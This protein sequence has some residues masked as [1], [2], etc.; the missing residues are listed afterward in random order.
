MAR[1]IDKDDLLVFEDSFDDSFG[2]SLEDDELDNLP[3]AAPGMAKMPSSPA[4]IPSSP[5]A[6]Q[7]SPVKQQNRQFEAD[8]VIDLDSDFSDDTPRSSRKHLTSLKNH[9]QDHA[10]QGKLTSM[11]NQFKESQSS[12]QPKGTRISQLCRSSPQK[13]E[14]QKPAP[15]KLAADLDLDE[16]FA[17]D[18]AEAQPSL[19]AEH[20]FESQTIQISGPET[21]SPTYHRLETLYPTIPQTRQRDDSPLK[22]SPSSGPHPSHTSTTPH[23]SFF[24]P[25]T[26]PPVKR[27]KVAL[28]NV[29]FSR[30]P[31][32]DENNTPLNASASSFKQTSTQVPA[33]ALKSPRK[34]LYP[35]LE[36]YD[37]RYPGISRSIFEECRAKRTQQKPDAILPIPPPQGRTKKGAISG[38]DHL[39]KRP[40]SKNPEL[41]L[42]TQRPTTGALTNA[43]AMSTSAS[44]KPKVVEPVILSEEQADVLERV[45]NGESL[46]YTGSAGTGKSVLLRSIIKRLKTMYRP[47]EVAVTASTGIAACNIGGVTLHSSITLQTVFRQKGDLEFIEMLNDMRLG[48]VTS[49]SLMKFRELERELDKKGKVEPAELFAT[50]AEVERANAYRLNS[51]N[52]QLYEYNALDGGFLTDEDQRFRLLQN[53]MA[54]PLLQLKKG[55]QVMMIKNIDGTL[56]NGSLGKVIDFIDRDTYLA[57]EM[58]ESGEFDDDKLESYIDQKLA[59]TV[60][61]DSGKSLPENPK[62]KMELKLESTVF[63]FLGEVRSDDAEQEQS[64]Q[65]KRDLMNKLHNSSRGQKLPLV[66]FLTPSQETRTVLV[67]PETWTVEDEKQKPLVSRTQLPLMLAWA[68]SIHKS[69]GQ[70]LPLVRVNL[71]RVFEKGQAYV[72]ISRAVSREGLQILNFDENKVFAHHKVIDFYNKL[73]TVGSKAKQKEKEVVYDGSVHPE[74]HTVSRTRYQ[75]PRVTTRARNID[76]AGSAFYNTDPDP[77]AHMKQLHDH[78]MA[79]PDDFDLVD[80]EWEIRR[81]IDD[82]SAAFNDTKRRSRPLPNISADWSGDDMMAATSEVAA[83]IAM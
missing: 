1:R 51:L 60:D 50:R 56:V 67:T 68:L 5:P 61:K 62:P 74:P 48:I 29:D 2:E 12:S 3:L 83:R 27:S 24:G 53:F 52:T 7:D 8:F 47:G 42:M 64:N 38:V 19:Q 63:D 23:G 41:M 37:E 40:K 33:T 6:S 71:K 26:K 69:Q 54:P 32:E 49:K 66:R 72:A 76:I 13:P 70:T 46:F 80:T 79:P 21:S 28:E 77:V 58:I 78:H 73:E 34:P 36:K 82:E 30:R 22:P 25:N 44:P 20:S 31:S 55:A 14:N 16:I 11:V 9:P 57:Y 18:L 10:T 75:P 65:R 43:R 59:S 45:V 81:D 39:M 4:A 17:D 15:K 35:V